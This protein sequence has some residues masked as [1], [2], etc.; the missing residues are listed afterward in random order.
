MG[1]NAN[2]LTVTS[3]LTLFNKQIAP[4]SKCFPSFSNAYDL[5]SAS[6][7]SM[8]FD[9]HQQLQST[10]LELCNIQNPSHQQHKDGELEAWLL[11]LSLGTCLE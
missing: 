9:P 5:K 11:N 4:L 6:N 8:H 3:N 1:H 7:I 10:S 2:N